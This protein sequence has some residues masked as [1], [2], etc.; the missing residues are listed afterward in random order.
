MIFETR[1]YF[2]E[3][4]QDP[5]NDWGFSYGRTD[6]QNIEDVIVDVIDGVSQTEKDVLLFCREISQD[7]HTMML[8]VELILARKSDF[9]DTDY[10]QADSENILPMKQLMHDVIYEKLD[11]EMDIS[12]F[13]MYDKLNEYD[14]NVT[15]VYVNI[16]AKYYE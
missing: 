11:C 12:K 15:G 2:E 4:A 14:V 9:R 3:I 8:N 16:I 13:N 10:K 5:A 1:T 7:P 6:Y